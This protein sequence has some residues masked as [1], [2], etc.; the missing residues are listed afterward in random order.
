MAVQRTLKNDE[1]GARQGA[2]RR[3][4]FLCNDEQ[5]RMAVQQTLKNDEIGARQSARRRIVFL[6]NDEQRAWLSSEPL[7][8][9]RLVPG[10]A[11]GGA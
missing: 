6:C 11:R 1:I 7:K 4:V 10:K 9:T 5:R 3:I 2:R 8:M